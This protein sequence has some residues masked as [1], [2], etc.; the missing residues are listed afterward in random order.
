MEQFALRIEMGNEAMQTPQDIAN[1][2]REAA[3][4][5]DRLDP[6]ITFSKGSIHDLN[7]NKVGKWEAS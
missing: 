2:L 7:G 4:K 3:D 1:A 6:E 5:L